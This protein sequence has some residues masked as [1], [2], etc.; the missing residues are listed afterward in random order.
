MCFQEVQQRVL[1]FVTEDMGDVVLQMLL[2]L[3]S[4]RLQSK[5]KRQRILVLDRLNVDQLAE[6]SGE[7]WFLKLRNRHL[8]IGNSLKD[9]SRLLIHFLDGTIGQQNCSHYLASIVTVIKCSEIFDDP[10]VV[11]S[12][13]VTNAEP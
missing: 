13:L 5:R 2:V 1:T 11:E 10:R 9:W 7:I 4:E 6:L 3:S 8:S 12:L